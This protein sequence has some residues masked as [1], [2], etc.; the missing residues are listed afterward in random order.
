MILT[1]RARLRYRKFLYCP[2]FLVLEVREQ[3]EIPD[4]VDKKIKYRWRRA[5]EDDLKHL[6]MIT[7]GGR[8]WLKSE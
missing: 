7:H 1:G 3:G 6:I 8:E 5:T 2:L 4:E